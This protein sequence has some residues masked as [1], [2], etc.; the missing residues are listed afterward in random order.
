MHT[1][2]VHVPHSHTYSIAKLTDQ[3]DKHLLESFFFIFVQNP[4]IGQQLSHQSQHHIPSMEL[5]YNNSCQQFSA[6]I[7]STHALTSNPVWVG[8]QAPQP[9]CIPTYMHITLAHSCTKPNRV[10]VVDGTS[11][12]RSLP[13]GPEWHTPEYVIQC[14]NVPSLK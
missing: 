2:C 4:S 6:Y 1:T 8:W 14:V 3:T 11:L 9:I 7:Y 5:Q 12:W 13:S 10:S